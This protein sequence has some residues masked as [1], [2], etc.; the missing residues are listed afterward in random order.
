MELEVKIVLLGATMVGKTSIVNRYIHGVFDLN[1]VSTIGAGFALKEVVADDVRVSLQIWDTAGQERYRTLAPVYY[2]NAHV[3][4]LVYDMGST[5]SFAD[6]STWSDELKDR[7]E[8]IFFTYIIA[9]KSDMAE[10]RSVSE[11]QG[12][13]KAEDLKAF[14]FETSAKTGANIEELFAHIS[15]HV[16]RSELLILNQQ[17]IRDEPQIVIP[18]D[19]ST[20]C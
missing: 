13:Q 1:Q 16:A 20:C 8:K 15:D 11:E 18:E 4:V 19:S 17:P 7:L 5:S 14:Y 6:V 2:H 10:E 3:A 12:Q 9:N